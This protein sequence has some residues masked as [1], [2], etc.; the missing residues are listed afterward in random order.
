MSSVVVIADRL[1]PFTDGSWDWPFR[2][3]RLDAGDITHER[4]RAEKATALLIRTRTLCD[5]K[6][7]E[8]TGI[9]F[10]GTA[11]IGTDHID[12][13]YCIQAGIEARG[14]PGCNSGAVMQYVASALS[15][16][17][18]SRECLPASLRLGI[19]GY[20]HVGKKVEKLGQALGM[21]VWINDPPLQELGGLNHSV[22]LKSI[23]E[24]CDI[25]TLHVPL[26]AE[27]RHPTL[28]LLGLE[29]TMKMKESSCLINTSRGRIV[30][31]KAL[32]EIYRMKP[33]LKYIADVWEQEPRIDP[34]V[35]SRSFLATPHIAG[36][37]ID[38]KYN[39]TLGI[40]KALYQ[41]FGWGTIPGIP[42]PAPP[43]DAVIEAD[44]LSDGFLAVYDPR[45]EDALLRATPS[46][47]ETL[48]SK[49]ALRHELHHYRLLTGGRV[50][51]IFP[52]T[53]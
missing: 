38:G 48:R 14:V 29:E 24:N 15:L 9:R 39:A 25:V 45:K 1:I 47:F 21:E 52:F 16:Y 53:G 12:R 42:A 37:S 26:E 34:E 46:A 33:G 51:K 49:Y 13:Q 10:I 8:N 36:Y 35:L 30:D 2:L 31:E 20:G 23:L 44:T 19:V 4:I 5:R 17:F 22:P 7:L 43:A 18:R 41:H 11:T 32:P 27:G 3:L 28:R 6:L 40:L 50:N